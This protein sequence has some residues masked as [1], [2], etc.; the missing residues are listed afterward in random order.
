M[1]HLTIILLFL[2]ASSYKAMAEKP[3]IVIILSDDQSWGDYSFMGHK[4]IKTPHLDQLAKTS[5][6][7]KRGYVPVALC[8][9]SLMTIMTGHYPHTHGV[10]GNDPHG[11]SANSKKSTWRESLISKIDKF[12]TIAD[13]LGEQGYLSHQ[14]GKWW[15]GNFK[16]GGFTHGM[17][18]GYPNKGG[19]HGDA[20]LKIGR[21]GLK[22]V[23]D[24]IKMAVEKKK[25]FFLWYAP[26]MPHTPHTPPKRILEKY[27][28]HKEL[29]H[30]VATYYAMCEWF[31]ETC[32]QLVDIL[33]KNKVRKNTLIIY[34]CDNGWI[35]S[36]KSRR[37]AP[38]SKRSPYEGGIRTPIFF[39]WPAKFKAADRKE[40]CTS[41][42]ILPTIC[43]ITGAR[44]P[45]KLPGLNLA[46]ACKN[47]DPIKRDYI[48][49][50]NFAHDIADI[51][52][53]EA[54]LLH[55]WCIKGKW[56]LLLTYDGNSGKSHNKMGEEKRPQ[57][58]DL[59]KDPAEEKNLAAENPQVV[60][61]LV[62]KIQAL[63]KVKER[64]VITNFI[65]GKKPNIIFFLTD[66]QRFDFLGCAGHP[67]LKTPSIDQL[68][69]QG[70][71]FT[72]AFVTTSTCWVS[73]TCLLTGLYMRTHKFTGGTIKKKFTETSYPRVLKD[74]GYNTAYIGKTH[75]ALE[76]GEQQKMFTYFKRIS[77]APYFKKMPDG[78]LRHETE[79]CGDEAIKFINRQTDDKPFFISV[80]F[81]ATHAE[82]GDKKN[83]YPYPKAVAHLYKDAKMPLPKLGDLEHFEINP[84]FLKKSMHTDRYKWRWNTAAKYQHNMRNYLRMATGID[85]V[86]G[87]VQKALKKAG[88]AENT[89]IIYSADNGY[90]AGN[91]RFAGKWTHYE[92]SLRVP[93]II[94]DPRQK[95]NRGQTPGQMALNIDIPATILNY[96]QLK[97]P[98]VYQ[99]RSL[100]G[101]VQGNKPKSW[102]Q[103]TIVEFFSQH[104]T[105]PNWQGLRGKRYVYAKYV[106]DDF[107][108]LH[109]LE[110]DPD[111][112]KN[113]ANDPEYKSILLHMRSRFKKVA[114]SYGRPFTKEDLKRYNPSRAK[115]KKKKQKQ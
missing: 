34:V 35:Q 10:T 3:N 50:E 17:T 42:D 85:N 86:I 46:D 54:S 32:G 37:Y 39:N 5:V 72:N 8:R 63:Y 84:E 28:K 87:R 48:L 93:L 71:R 101:I 59:S 47:G 98:D 60:A 55:R 80:N 75:F 29:P 77:R 51:S 45:A 16:R 94:F 33:E 70:T 82:D 26:F 78:S 44:M 89:I 56:K 107:E 69:A 61:E 83:H 113:F 88:F 53:P 66:D 96:A 64:K 30:T 27:L 68:A 20:G 13:V 108:F 11:D 58:F 6:L 31:D 100:V 19:R 106:D 90:Y 49:G 14:S 2:L 22:P 110:K 9:P 65:A 24:F 109:D 38:R 115:F 105:I 15:E 4:Y 62:Q 12:D 36:P 7:F 25:P 104:S 112:L 74:G 41:L 99:G 23:A 73:R 43:G 111:Q 114:D 40:L 18:K 67:V 103:D 57:L 92:E 1:R 52:N 21:K 91:R 76:K 97:T 79:L 95:G 102:R 81:N